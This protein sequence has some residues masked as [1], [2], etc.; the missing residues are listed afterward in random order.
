MGTAAWYMFD[1]A[2][3]A[4]GVYYFEGNR[5]WKNATHF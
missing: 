4:M 1:R 3:D 2:Y 5:T